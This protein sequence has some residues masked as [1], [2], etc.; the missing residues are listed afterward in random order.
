MEQN[1][2]RAMVIVP[3][4]DELENVQALV[5]RLLETASTIDVLVVD[6]NSPDGTGEWVAGLA[7]KVPRVHCIRRPRK[8]GLGSAYVEGFRFA[9]ARGAELIFEMDADFSHDPEDIPRFIAAARDA[10][11]VLGSRYLNGVTVVN[12][13]LRRLM[14][15]YT[16]NVLSRFMTGLPIKDATGGFKC[17]HRKVLESIDLD[18]IHSDGYSFQ[19]EVSF[20]AWR[21]GFRICEIPIVFVDRRAGTSKMSRKI[22]FEAV[23]VLWRLFF[24]RIFR[25]S[26]PLARVTHGEPHVERG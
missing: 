16:A 18:R 25:R 6:D 22:I 4:Y 2:P 23:F 26:R 9:L 10:D 24:I 14:L 7:A 20:H 12:W 21:K 13:P 5:P 1:L 15:S 8:M 19:I 17:F 11:L 3:T